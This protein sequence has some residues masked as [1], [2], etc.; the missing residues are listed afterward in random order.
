MRPAHLEPDLER[1]LCLQRSLN[2]VKATLN[3]HKLF[4]FERGCQEA[5][6]HQYDEVLERLKK[7][8][9]ALEAEYLVPLRQ[10]M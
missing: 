6:Q 4:A 1:L 5:W 8:D 9:D 2:K 7:V 3:N 10:L